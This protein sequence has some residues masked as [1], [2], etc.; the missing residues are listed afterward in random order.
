MPEYRVYFFNGAGRIQSVE[1]I[2][3]EGDAEA[4]EVMRSTAKGRAAE[5]WNL[6]RLVGRHDREAAAS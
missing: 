1:E 4:L 3:C 2:A 6:A 5:L